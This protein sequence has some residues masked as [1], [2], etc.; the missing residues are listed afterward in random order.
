MQEFKSFKHDHFTSSKI[1]G[2]DNDNLILK[3]ADIGSKKSQG[4]DT[5]HIHRF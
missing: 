5:N 2:S 3:Q 4:Y 1:Y